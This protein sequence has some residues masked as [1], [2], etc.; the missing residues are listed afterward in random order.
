MDRTSLNPSNLPET[1]AGDLQLAEETYFMS[2][3]EQIYSAS[4]A[5]ASTFEPLITPEGTGHKDGEKRLLLSLNRSLLLSQSDNN[6]IIIATT[7]RI[8]NK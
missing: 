3:R 5:K 7:E 1:F 8:R 6:Y 2:E 4:S